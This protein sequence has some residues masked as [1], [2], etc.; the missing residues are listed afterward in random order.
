MKVGDLVRD[1]HHAVDRDLI[2]RPREIGVIVSAANGALGRHLKST[3]YWEI[4]WADGLQVVLD[5]DL[6]VINESR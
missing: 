4:M 5:E 3:R 2:L 6:E 1:M